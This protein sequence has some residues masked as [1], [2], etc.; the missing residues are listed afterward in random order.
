MIHKRLRRKYQWVKGRLLICHAG[1]AKYGFVE[2]GL[3]AFESKTTTDYHEEI[4][5][6]TFKEWF[7]NVL[8]PGLPEPSVIFMDNAPYHSVQVQKAP[9]RVNRKEE[10][11]AWLQTNGIDA[12]MQMLKAE[13]IKLVKDNKPAIVRYEIDELALEYGHRVLRIPPYHCQYN[14][15]ELIWAQ[16]KG[17]AARHNI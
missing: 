2:N 7:Q 9:T 17:Y 3:L 11:V 6:A 16:I 12:N 5:A 14:A 1:S 8:L 10:L 13:Q 4:N 15:I